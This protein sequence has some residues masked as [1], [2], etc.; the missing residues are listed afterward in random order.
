MENNIELDAE[1]AA[2]VVEALSPL[3]NKLTQALEK[4]HMHISLMDVTQFTPGTWT[5]FGGDPRAFW[6]AVLISCIHIYAWLLSGWRV[7]VF[8]VLPTHMNVAYILMTI[9]RRRLM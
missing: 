9:L 7:P 8:A 4:V 2:K 3:I 1:K 6:K 5:G